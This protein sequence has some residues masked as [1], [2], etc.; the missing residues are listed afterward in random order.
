M[1][2]AVAVSFL[3]GCCGYLLA[4][5]P[6][7]PAHSRALDE[8]VQMTRT[9]ASDEAVLAFARAHRR[10]LPS[11]VSEQDLQWLHASGV[12]DR[13]VR[14]LWAVDVRLPETGG[15]EGVT[16]GSG[17]V[18]PAPGPYPYDT[19]PPDNG[20]SG[21]PDDGYAGYDS[22]SGPYDDSGFYDYWYTPYFNAYPFAYYPSYAYPYYYP[23]YAFHGHGFHGHNGHVDHHDGHGHWASNSGHGNAADSWRSGSSAAYRSAPVTSGSRG[24]GRPVYA[25]GTFASRPAISRG[26]MAGRGGMSRPAPARSGMTRGFAGPRGGAVGHGGGHAPSGSS[27]G[28]GR[29]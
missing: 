29:R 12:S 13:V 18:A 16:Y 20:S 4:D 24:S 3:I 8:I 19:Y 25:R 7:P 5:A 2:R 21:S 28:H 11:R 9:G 14:Y 22:P 26:A 23:Y 10:E 6:T 17:Q 1:K 15:P 27:G